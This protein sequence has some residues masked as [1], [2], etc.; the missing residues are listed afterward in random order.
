MAWL[1]LGVAVIR[2]DH[3]TCNNMKLCSTVALVIAVTVVYI[4]RVEAQEV[5]SEDLQYGCELE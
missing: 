2:L 5:D 4:K 3:S 1:P